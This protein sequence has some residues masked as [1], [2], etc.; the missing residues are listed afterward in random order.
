MNIPQEMPQQNKTLKVIYKNSG[1]KGLELITKLAED[2]EKYK[3]FCEVRSKN[4]KLRIHEDST[5]WQWYLSELL[6]YHTSQSGYEMA[7]ISKRV[8]PMKE[9]QKSIC[10][11]T[12][13]S[14]D[15]IANSAFMEHMKK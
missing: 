10:Y 11:L 7:F 2:K 8:S 15:W 13:E 3:K 12:T 6:G 14:K 5:N 9:T 4:L 1:K